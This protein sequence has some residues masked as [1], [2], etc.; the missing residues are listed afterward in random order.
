MK[1][2]KNLGEFMHQVEALCPLIQK[3]EQQAKLKVES[4][5]KMGERSSNILLGEI[6]SK[7]FSAQSENN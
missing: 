7:V 3:K 4:V 6:L 1:I 2:Q 5:I